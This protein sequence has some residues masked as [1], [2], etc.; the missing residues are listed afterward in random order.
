MLTR[1][2]HLEALLRLDFEPV[3][4]DRPRTLTREEIAAFNQRGYLGPRRVFDGGALREVQAFFRERGGEVTA[5]DAFESF[6]H[7]VPELRRIVTHPPTL[8]VL[9]DLT[10]PNVVC[11]ISQY[12]NKPP[13][14][15]S[16]G[17]AA[18]DDSDGPFHQDATFNAMDA[19]GIVAWLAI[20]DADAE[21]GCMWFIPGSHRAGAVECD[22]RHW[23]IE[24]ERYGRAIPMPAKA[25][26]AI[27]F[28]DLLM[29]AS[30]PNRSATRD[31][32]AFTSTYCPAET[33]PHEKA[34]RWAVL[35]AGRDASGW[36][37]R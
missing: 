36:W 7:R 13:T 5:G 24:P 3:R 29:H 12:I 6:H 15:G 4:N 2:P 34:E 22:R 25:G 18:I 26:E 20:H 33:R 17:A 37:S 27:F 32:P 28:S 8:A 1:Y 10:G 31:R 23:V 9:T 14:P 35:C 11:H 16:G 21:N 19:R 30:P